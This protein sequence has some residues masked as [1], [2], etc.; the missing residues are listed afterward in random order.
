MR[1]PLLVLL[2]LLAVSPLA[3]QI[4]AAEYTARRDSLAATMDDGILLALGGEEPAEDFLTFY[5]APSFYYLT[6]VTEPDAA[7]VMVKRK[8]TVYSML[9]VEPRDPAREAWTGA[10]LG[11][12]GMRRVT[13]IPSR[14]MEQLVPALDSLLALSDRLAVIGNLGGDGFETR[15]AQFV[16]SLRANHPKLRVLPANDLV[17]RLRMRHSA[18][19]LA[20][21]RKAIDITVRAQHDAISAI[22]PGV[23]EFEIQA[24]IDYTFRRNG[25]DRPSFATTVGSGPNS[26]ALHYSA[27]DGYM[28]AGD[29]VVMDIGASYRGYAADVTR[30]VPVS[31]TFTPEQRAIY[32][33]VRDAQHAA[34][35]AAKLG[36]TSSD[37]DA[38]ANK[39]LGEGLAKLGLIES[40][41]ATFDNGAPG[42]QRNI[43]RRCS[44]LSLFY[45]H[46]LGHAIGLE[47]HDPTS[48][49]IA[50]GNTFTIEPGIYVRATVLDNLP[51]TPRNRAIIAKLRPVVQRYANI[52]VR[53]EDDYFATESGV[54]WISRGPREVTEI[55]QMMRIR[56]A[57]PAA[58]DSSMVNWYRQTEPITH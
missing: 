19:E 56:A 36:A 30:T 49:R 39:V 22:R 4:P 47:V 10:R 21:E 35:L 23:N 58:R 25:A 20:L 29:V 51:D 44:Q 50:P 40:P 26:T 52:G 2:S 55:E 16:A 18:A 37:M 3:A 32:Q 28:Q 38:A 34:E 43:A 48:Y 5:P 41:D 9:F 6:G 14:S 7:L 45:F 46:A 33:L 12:D 31:G 27:N 1:R 24:L 53:I 8:G 54:E 17:A 42:C 13:G 15:D 11:V 57:V